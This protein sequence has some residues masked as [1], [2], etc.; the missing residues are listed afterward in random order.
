MLYHAFTFWGAIR[1]NVQFNTVDQY[2]KDIYSHLNLNITH[3]GYDSEKYDS[4]GYRTYQRVIKKLRCFD[5][6]IDN[7]AYVTFDY[8]GKESEILSNFDIRVG[9]REENFKLYDHVSPN[10]KRDICHF[11][12]K[13]QYISNNFEEAILPIFKQL[14][15]IVLDKNEYQ[16]F[17]TEKHFAIYNYEKGKKVEDIPDIASIRVLE[18]KIYK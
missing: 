8:T 6:E 17:V 4:N 16:H 10:P 2:I 11:V 18:R 3:I 9:I 5:E 7:L 12:L 13:N 15:N 14:A 1:K